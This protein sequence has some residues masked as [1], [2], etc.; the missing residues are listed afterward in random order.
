[1]SQPERGRPLTQFETRKVRI[2]GESN[3]T[4]SP[5][6]SWAPPDAGAGISHS[7]RPDELVAG[8][9][10]VVR[11]I[12][13]G[14]HGEVY[15]AEDQEVGCLVALKTIRPE[16]ALDPEV[17]DRFRRELQLARRVTHPNVCRLF[18]LGRH[19]PA[20]V[21]G[22]SEP[23]PVL[24]LTMELLSGRTLAER[25][26]Q[27]GPMRPEEALPIV[28]QMAAALQAAHDAGV[29]HRDF[30]GG[31]VLLVPGEPGVRVVVTD[32]GVARG[33]AAADGTTASLTATGN[34][35]GTPAYMA[36][37]QVEGLAVG[38]AA[39]IY[40]LGVVL[41]EMVS[42]RRP[43]EGPTTMSTMVRRLTEPASSPRVHVPSLPPAW[44]A[45]ILRCLERDPA[46]RF[47]RAEDVARALAG[48]SPPPPLPRR[49]RR[50]ARIAAASA[51]ALLLASAASVLLPSSA[52]PPSEHSTR[53]SAAILGFKN[54]SGS[55]EAAYL[56]TVFTEMLGMEL[57]AGE[58]L[59]ILPGE[60]VGRMKRELRISET[61]ELAG[62]TLGR[63]RENL[64]S[65]L[66][67]LGSY[68]ALGKPAGGRIRLD[69]RIQD[70]RQGRTI[71]RVSATG[72]EAGLLDLVT[73]AGAELRER[74]GIGRLSSSESGLLDASRPHS[75]EAARLYA[76]GLERLRFFDAQAA[77]ELL[78]QA[79]AADPSFALGHWALATAW[80][81]LG[82]DAEAREEAG[83][84][85]ALAHGLPRQERLLVEARD[86]EIRGEWDQAIELYRSVWELHSDSLDFGLRLAEAQLA[87]ARA[88]DV[89][90][91]VAMLRAL[92][93]PESGD[94]RIDLVEAQAAGM[95]T[96]FRRQLAAA[97]RAIALGEARGARHLAARALLEKGGALVRLGNPQEAARCD[98][99]AKQI[100]E[101]AGDRWGMA[102]AI[103]R[104]AAV[105]YDRGD[106]AAAR[107]LFEE[108]LALSRI[109]GDRKSIGR[110]LGNLAETL[111]NLGDLAG[112][113]R[114]YQEAMPINRERSSSHY[115][116]DNLWGLGLVLTAQGDLAGAERMYGECLAIARVNGSQ[117]YLALAQDGLSRILLAQ[118][119]LAGARE[120]QAAALE[121]WQ[122]TGQRDMAALS[123]LVLAEIAAA[124]DR[125]GEAE[126]LARQAVDKLAG[127]GFVR[128][129][130]GARAQLADLLLRQGRTAEAARELA[131]AQELAEHLQSPHIRLRVELAA[132]RG[133]AAAGKSAAAAETLGRAAEEARRLGLTPLQLEARLALGLLERGTP[134]G[135]SRLEAL[136]QEADARRLVLIARGAAAALE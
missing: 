105:P 31:N 30:K 100:F 56:S 43:F 122:A 97:E 32:F 49:R 128:Q 14:A 131:R 93:A 83:K 107:R 8:R 5:T 96:D 40:A 45:T 111:Y 70:T 116:A 44:E 71:A 130:A 22:A 110:Q 18:D 47:R 73:G 92:P 79:V 16:I 125:M 25:L 10:R 23:A 102:R 38:P 42:G 98:R 135:R 127:L 104:M 1:M 12:A 7:F 20:A 46:D 57:G 68:L 11:Y 90:E 76:E 109:T 118:A 37:E 59:R 129:E 65:D 17:L 103:N 54:L 27:D 115:L 91:T 77:R 94:P 72:T 2:D 121:V 112:A 86:R 64:G 80:A 4:E 81:A 48:E 55:P 15:A 117:R 26:R 126:Q 35:M 124:A 99:R 24:F 89:L 75:A 63:I 62:D 28:R 101:E 67:L 51:A 95:L 74:L 61:E 52:L 29:V 78:S 132:A 21:P 41:Y 119:D 84:A 88:Q 53:R 85:V 134:E 114:L 136:R 87:A 19:Q 3:P 113:L 6:P 33:S 13:G 66:V 39:D 120:A 60:T 34:L 106:Y 58:E 50:R 9:Y 133:L 123:R 69:L 108:S 82:H 36:P